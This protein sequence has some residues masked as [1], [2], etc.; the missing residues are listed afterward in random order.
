MRLFHSA[1]YRCTALLVALGLCTSGTFAISVSLWVGEGAYCS[2]PTG[3]LY[4]DV[5]G[6][7]AP[8]TYNWY[9]QDLGNWVPVCM[10][11]TGSLQ[12]LPEFTNYKVLVTDALSATAEATQTVPGLVSAWI[13]DLAHYP[14]VQG[15]SPV[16]SYTIYGESV[17]GGINHQTAVNPNAGTGGFISGS[18]HYSAALPVSTTFCEVTAWAVAPSAATTCPQ[19]WEGLPIGSPTVLPTL[20]TLQVL[21]SCSNGSTGRIDY[22]LT[23]G[24]IPQGIFVHLKNGAGSV[25]NSYSFDDWQMPTVTGAFTGVAPGTYR[26]VVSGLPLGTPINF[27]ITGF[28]YTCRDSITVVV[29]STGES[30]GQAQGS[31]FIDTNL[32]C[33]LQGGEPGVPGVVLK[34]LPGP[35]FVNTTSTGAYNLQLPAGNYTINE[36]HAQIGQNCSASPIPFT[37]PAVITPVVV[38]VPCTSLVA[39]DADISISSGPARPGFPM[40]Y[41]VQVRNLTPATTG[42]ITITVQLDPSLSFTSANPAPTSAAAGTLTWTQAALAPFES[43]SINITTQVPNDVGLLGTSL[44]TT[45][46]LA[47]TVTD[48]ALGNNQA[49]CATVVTGSYDPNDKVALTSSGSRT[50]YDPT[51]D[52]WIDY[53]IRFQN[54]GTDTAFTVVITDTLPTNLDPATLVIGAASHSFTWT[55]RGARTLRFQFVNIGL[56]HS[57]IN[58]PG[59]HG[60]VSFRIRPVLPLAAG[61]QISNRAN[62][63]FDFNAPVITDPSVLTVPSPPVLVSP[64]VYLGG[65]YTAGTPPLSD[66]L[67]VQGR[68][69]LMEPYT[70][71]GYTHTGTGGD[72]LVL[73]GVLQITGNDAIVDWVVVELRQSGGAGAVV[74]SRSALLQRDGD[75]V[76]PNGA[77]PVAFLVAPGGS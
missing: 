23:N 52:S 66:A 2:Q 42:S 48:G 35:H 74:A 40:Q 54:T 16:I 45:A 39:M 15:A 53:V 47:T 13:A 46:A 34:V 68:V 37:V 77:S 33:T 44:A 65:A 3:F 69:P 67:R 57:A 72:E 4:A 24:V 20:T 51:Q 14:Y 11:C 22:A 30:C 50:H 56:P 21:P 5:Q 10:G 73:P 31:V 26:L 38:N 28:N 75:V 62:I 76:A 60:F 70:A 61:A 63:Y 43:R 29:P 55:L 49:I 41:A 59:S 19:D 1:R 17:G 27:G 6:G 36:E 32:N 58:E 8:F 12:N 9:R 71:L 25:L 7:S 18:T 64:R